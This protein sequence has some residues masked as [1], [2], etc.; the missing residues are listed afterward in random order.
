MKAYGS[1]RRLD[2]A[3]GA[4][5]NYGRTSQQ[6]VIIEEENGGNYSDEDYED[7]NQETTM[8]G[9]RNTAKE[10]Q[11]KKYAGDTGHDYG[12]GHTYHEE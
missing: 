4:A 10:G 5:S 9:G 12:G 1:E 6:Q 11:M 8:T 3:E 2:T 7:L